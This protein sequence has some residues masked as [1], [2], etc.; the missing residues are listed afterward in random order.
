LRYA[1]G[2]HSRPLV[3]TFVSYTSRATSRSRYL[4]RPERHNA[5]DDAFSDAFHRALTQACGDPE[6]RVLPLRG[7]GASFSSGRDVAML[8]VRP[9]GES[10]HDFAVAHQ[11]ARLRLLVCPK[12]VVVAMKGYVLGGGLETALA[13]D[14]R[15]VA[16]DTLLGFP[17]VTYGLMTDT[18]GAPLTTTLA[19]RPGR[20]ICS[21]RGAGSTPSR[22]WAIRAGL[23]AELVAQS[24]LFAS[25]DF[26]QAKAARA[27]AH[28]P[29]SPG[30]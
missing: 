5:F 21:C 4:N 6:V 19:G 15:L 12:P 27:A 30:R 20:S 26:A 3:E 8:G 7:E 23:R 10:D 17:E 18:G 9:G 28:V 11:A 16:S 1:F 2:T 13:G 14:M 24:S 29:Q 22:P 25:E